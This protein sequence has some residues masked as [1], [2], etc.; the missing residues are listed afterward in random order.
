MKIDIEF[1]S[2]ARVA[3]T[4]AAEIVEQIKP[5]QEAGATRIILPYVAASDDVVNEVNHFIRSWNLTGAG[6]SSSK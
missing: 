1:N 6:L 4:S 2:G 5:Y 3:A